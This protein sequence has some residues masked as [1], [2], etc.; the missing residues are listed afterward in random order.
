MKWDKAIFIANQTTCTMKAIAKVFSS[1]KWTV[2]S[3]DTHKHAST[4]ELKTKVLS[5]SVV[6]WDIVNPEEALWASQVVCS[7]KKERKFFLISTCMTW[8]RTPLPPKPDILDDEEADEDEEAEPWGIGEEDFLSRL[9]HP[10]YRLH[11]SVERSI[12]KKIRNTANVSGCIIVPGHV[13]GRG[14]G[15][16]FDLFK[17]AW[18][19]EKIPLY[20]D[21]NRIIPTIHALDLAIYVSECVKTVPEVM[22]VFAVEKRQT[23]AGELVKAI[24][25]S[26]RMPSEEEYIQKIKDADRKN[27][28]VDEDEEEEGDDEGE[29]E[30][31]KKAPPPPIVLPPNVRRVDRTEFLLTSGIAD[32]L[33]NFPMKQGHIA[34]VLEEA[35]G[36]L[37]LKYGFIGCC[38]IALDEYVHVRHVSPLIVYIHGPPGSGKSTV[39]AKLAEQY[40]IEHV[41]V[42]DALESVARM[43]TEFG[44][45]VRAALEQKQ[46]LSD[47]ACCIALRTYIL[48][49]DRCRCRGFVLDGYPKSLADSLALF[50]VT[51]SGRRI[52]D[53]SYKAVWDK[54]KRWKRRDEGK[55]DEEEDEEE[56]GEEEELEE[57]EVSVKSL[58][59]YLIQPFT[60]KPLSLSLGVVPWPALVIS[61]SELCS[62]E[63]RRSRVEE[64]Y[65][66][67]DGT[68]LCV[69]PDHFTLT[70]FNRRCIAFKERE[71][72][73]GEGKAF[74]GRKGDAEEED[75]GAVDVEQD[76]LAFLLSEEPDEEL[77]GPPVKEG[78]EGEGDEEEGGEKVGDVFLGKMR[79]ALN[80]SAPGPLRAIEARGVPIYRYGSEQ[81][82]KGFEK[83]K[84]NQQQLPSTLVPQTLEYDLLKMIT[85]CTE[86]VGQKRS[87]EPTKEEILYKRALMAR[88][89]EEMLM[90]EEARTREQLRIQK[91]EEEE[92]ER[93]EKEKIEELRKEEERL[94][95]VRSAPIRRFLGDT[96]LD[97]VAL[98]LREVGELRPDDP[99]EYLAEF[100]MNKAISK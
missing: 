55:E 73:E 7:D 72:A 31:K 86:I 50:G 29:E 17:A 4:E 80:K 81:D 22:Y 89:Q 70:A 100:L 74:M 20:G 1:L 65:G 75:E 69:T 88:Q 90:K 76:Y 24:A 49:N 25:E 67:L 15:V 6:I 30:K 96:V 57:G 84:L 37:C 38:P 41:T 63:E 3:H 21:E 64:E 98:G 92:R 5:C 28:I 10:E 77:E 27:G 8:A 44:K 34:T 87:F 36:W 78:E 42:H 52:R 54:V 53:D 43:D 46:R 85:V 59:K 26:V 18:L 95:D 83:F 61:L 71:S 23:T 39:A 11:L 56:E 12:A 14:E 35:P 66:Q 91:K 93:L 45:R 62:E 79:A 94:L 33:I 82:I 2:L 19:G 68:A 32:L 47:S 60:R 40:D 97:I 99:V 51:E 48:H 9:S 13:Y 16:F 58:R